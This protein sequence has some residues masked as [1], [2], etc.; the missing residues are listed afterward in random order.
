[1]STALVQQK[2]QVRQIVTVTA[3]KNKRMILM[4]GLPSCGK[5]TTSRNIAAREGG[6]V[7]EFDSYF[8]TQV[9]NDPTEYNWSKSLIPQAREWHYGRVRDAVERGLSPIIVDNNAHLNMRTRKMVNH[10]VKHGYT[11]E[12]REPDAPWWPEIRPL[13]QNYKA[14]KKELK[15]WAKHLSQ[16]NQST[17]RVSTEQIMK[18]A[19]RWIPHLTVEDIMDYE[20]PRVI[21]TEEQSSK[22]QRIGGE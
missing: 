22:W 14:N 11:I 17:H 6:V 13:L 4:R 15:K 18:K 1:M 5:S 8:N 20:R 3:T 19:Q 2:T 10:A 16:L 12:L 21:E 7:Y 9:G